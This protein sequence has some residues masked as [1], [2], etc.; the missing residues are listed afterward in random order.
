MHLPPIRFRVRQLFVRLPLRS[1]CPSHRA[2]LSVE[3]LYEMSGC[4]RDLSNSGSHG[5]GTDK[6]D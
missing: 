3:D 4:G 1:R 6:A 5:A 2:N